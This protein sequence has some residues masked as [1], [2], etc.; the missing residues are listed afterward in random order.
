MRWFVAFAV[1]SAMALSRRSDA[2]GD[3]GKPLPL[4]RTAI[5][6]ADTYYVEGRVR[7]GKRTEITLG[8][9]TKIVGRGAGAVIEVEGELQGIAGNGADI[10]FEDVSI[11]PQA[12]FVEI[13][14]Q[15]AQ[16]QG[17][18]R[19]IV[20]AKDA[21]VAGK[22]A[23][24]D[25]DFGRGATLDLVMQS[26]SVEILDSCNF[27]DPVSIKAVA[28]PGTKGNAVKVV[29]ENCR[30]AHGLQGGI[31]VEGA[32]DV[33]LATTCIEGEVLSFVDC[34][35]MSIDGCLIQCKRV[36]LTEPAAGRFVKSKFQRCDIQCEK[37]VLTGPPVDAI[38][39]VLKIDGCWFG[40]ETNP[41]LAKQKFIDDH[42]SVSASGVVA[43][44]TRP[45]TK[46]LQIAGNVKR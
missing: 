32:S 16:F 5:L 3:A 18:S 9:N 2:G 14:L 35:V 22:V 46:P 12:A 8:R 38:P 28:P 15:T 31:R 27:F 39:E 20:S 40:G 24:Q 37:I 4:D 44:V 29:V 25:V 36:E 7:I 21:Q 26:G 45:E 41:R 33:S 11:E 34:G 42:D 30:Y 10:I 1:L 6:K 19:G 17:K 43:Q 13:H 23:L